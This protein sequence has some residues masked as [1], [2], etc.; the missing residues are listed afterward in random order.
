MKVINL[1]FIILKI[2]GLIAA[3]YA[4]MSKNGSLNVSLVPEYAAFLK[5][6]EIK[7]V[8]INGSTGDFVSLSVKERMALMDAW[9][10]QR[11]DEFMVINHVGST[12]LFEA[13]ELA[14]HAKDKSD[15]FAAI[16]PYYFKMQ[17]LDKLIEYCREIA[18]A[19]PDL[20]FYYYHLP[21]LS[22]ANLNMKEFLKS[23]LEE[24]SNLAGIKYTSEDLVG[25]KQAHDFKNGLFDVL[26]G[27]DE[28]F[29]NSLPFGVKGWVGSTYNHLAPLYLEIKSLFE[30]GN[31]QKASE[32]QGMAI[33]FVQL[34]ASKGGFNGAGK[35]YMKQ[36]GLDFG[37]SRFPHSTLSDKDFKDI[38]MELEKSGIKD[39]MTKP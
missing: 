18:E 39:H 27:Y 2:Q 6:N 1:I 31:M 26:F 8:F 5:E 15:A 14:A 25:F 4:P 36:L 23:G 12:N 21:V 30:D 17:N 35:S 16:A 9:T 37:P 10:Q 32:L 24:I 28:C 29:L 33:K 3:A 7:G 38:D 11:S 13:K 22:G 19:A 34:L 20:P